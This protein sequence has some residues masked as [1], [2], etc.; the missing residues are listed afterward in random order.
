MDELRRQPSVEIARFRPE[1]QAAVQRL[2]LEGLEEHWG[3][4]DPQFNA[5]LD[6]I[7]AS[8]AV[9]TVLLARD[10]GRIVGVGAIIPVAPG[11]GEVKRMSVARDARRRGLG[12][13]LLSA[14]L[15]DAKERGWRSVRLE[16]T[17]DWEDAV[18]FYGAFGFEQ[19]HYEV[20]AFGRD[21]YFRMDL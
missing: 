6:D 13:A 2:I 18:Q 20:G 10:S 8:Y 21:A 7:E 14:L 19:T 4:L 16:T 11:E 15:E 9:G 1:D 5:D 17:A 3:V 12:T